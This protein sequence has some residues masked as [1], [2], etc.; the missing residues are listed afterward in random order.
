MVDARKIWNGIW[1]VGGQHLSDINDCGVFLIA[2]GERELVLV[3]SGA[4]PSVD[5][6]FA[7]IRGTGN[8][9]KDLKALI[10]THGHADHIGGA[11]EMHE[12]T[13]CRIIA[14]KDDADAIEGRNAAKTAA[15][16]YGLE[17]APVTIDDMVREGFEVR[18][19]AGAELLLLHTPGHTPGSI[20]AYLDRDSKRVLFG[21]DIHGPFDP[22]FGSD[23][24]EWRRS[25]ERLLEL[26]ADILCEGHY[27]VYE[28]KDRVRGYIQRY[29]D[30]Y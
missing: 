28:G 1:E 13:G 22:V 29:L 4:G 5:R 26:E 15:S 2:C 7:N 24:N 14:H 23:L 12:R 10:L 20:A 11:C 9:P 16:W 21:Q 18:R 19:F 17:L 27:G 8:D 25:M 3:D 30:S 6:I